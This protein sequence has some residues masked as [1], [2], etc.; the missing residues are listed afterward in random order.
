MI[1][2]HSSYLIIDSSI[3]KTFSDQLLLLKD[4]NEISEI[5]Y[6][7][8]IA[9][10]E[11]VHNSLSQL[12][13]PT[14]VTV[15]LVADLIGKVEAERLAEKVKREE[16]ERSNLELINNEKSAKALSA[17]AL[18][19]RDAAESK[20]ERLMEYTSM[21]EKFTDREPE[22]QQA[23]V[24]F[25]NVK[26]RNIVIRYL[27]IISLTFIVRAIEYAI[28]NNKP[29]LSESSLFTESFSCANYL[30]LCLVSVL[31]ALVSERAIQSGIGMPLPLA[32]LIDR[33]GFRKH[34]YAEFI[35]NNPLPERPVKPDAI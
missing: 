32:M 13:S 35:I 26:A 12:I 4:K 34:L 7:R 3:W 2:M 28:S 24:R 5:Q 11:I 33:K 1:K 22:H 6:G 17:S 27:I 10:N 25:A 31:V 23:F 9:K 21:Y 30:I 15:D 20:L 14:D 8:M 16:L 29:I 19:E 18:E